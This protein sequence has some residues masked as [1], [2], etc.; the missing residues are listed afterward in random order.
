M[1]LP[2]YK[3][4]AEDEFGK[5]GAGHAAGGVTQSYYYTVGIHTVNYVNRTDFPVTG[6]SFL[7]DNML[8]N[9]GNY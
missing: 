9:D 1:V 2:P 6:D 5:E 7:K 4:Q 3:I 8:G